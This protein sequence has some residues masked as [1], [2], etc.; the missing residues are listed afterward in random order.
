MAAMAKKR[1]AAKAWRK[2]MAWHGM[3]A[4]SERRK[5]KNDETWWRN[6]KNGKIARIDGAKVN[7]SGKISAK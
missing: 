4:R 7:V 3:A 2:I 1:K 6:E 5:I